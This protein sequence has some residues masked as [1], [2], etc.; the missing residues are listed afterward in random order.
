MGS[1]VMKMYACGT[2]KKLR[3]YKI[4]ITF[5]KSKESPEERV[6]RAHDIRHDARVK[7]RDFMKDERQVEELRDRDLK[8]YQNP[9]GPTFKYLIENNKNEGQS[10]GEV[11]ESIVG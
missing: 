10:E 4:K 1:S 6:K 8:K 9:D 5:G 7:A 3:P 11:Y 2:T